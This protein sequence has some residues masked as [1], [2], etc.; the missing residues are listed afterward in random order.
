MFWDKVA[1]VYDVFANV[2]NAKTHKELCRNIEALIKPN[3]IILECACG[4]GMLSV[5]IAPRC[6]Q[7]IATDYSKNMLKRAEK[8]CKSFSNAVFQKC[9]ICRLDY[10]DQTFDKV[11]AANVIH[12]LDDPMIAMKEL[13]RV[14]KSGGLMII[15]TYINRDS[16]GKN[17]SFSSAVGKAGAD[18]KRQFTYT[19]YQDFF[20][21]A[22]Y[23]R[24]E[25]KLI[26]GRVPC[27]VAFV[28]KE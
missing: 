28:H 9:D 11:V 18:F 3:D 1:C 7:L 2:I 26:Q 8:K 20:V 22:G 12:L 4:T 27:A 14:C 10:P 21:D 17:S 19:S 25:Y 16:K 6:K 13:D 5:H 24:V 23:K 15:P